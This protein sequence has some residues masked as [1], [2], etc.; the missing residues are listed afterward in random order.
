M[1]L[2]KHLFGDIPK[3]LHNSM[4]DVLACLRCYGKMQFDIVSGLC[5][6]LYILFTSRGLLATIHPSIMHLLVNSLLFFGLFDIIFYIGHR[7]IHHPLLYSYI[8]KLH[9]T[10]FANTAISGYYM[11]KLDFL[12][13]FMLPVYIPIYLL[14]AN[15]LVFFV[16]T[17]IAQI[18]G[19]VSHGG[20]NLPYIPYSKDHLYH[21]LEFNCNYGIIFMDD[22]FSTKK[23]KEKISIKDNGK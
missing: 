15:G 6:L 8:H 16:C 10:T 11:S 9:H 17:L 5:Y 22:L 21:H 4:V 18:N 19:L 1:E 14:N 20:Y 3:G 23:I 2:H 7:T 13:E 12:V